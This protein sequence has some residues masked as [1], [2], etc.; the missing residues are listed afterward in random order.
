MVLQP[1]KEVLVRIRCCLMPTALRPLP[2]QRPARKS[3]PCNSGVCNHGIAVAA[4]KAGAWQWRACCG[5]KH[6]RWVVL[7][8]CVA[9][10]QF[11]MPALPVQQPVARL[12]Q[13][14]PSLTARRR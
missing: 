4:G 5:S 1:G 10:R 8:N 3:V 11:G 2:M 12:I 13:F 6:R 9:V 14:H 7:F